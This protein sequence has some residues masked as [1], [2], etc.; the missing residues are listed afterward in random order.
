MF[1]WTDSDNVPQTFAHKV[2]VVRAST[3]CDLAANRYVMPENPLFTTDFIGGSPATIT[4]G[5][6]PDSGG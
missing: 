2:T 6:F 1:S 4:L 5:P 3:K